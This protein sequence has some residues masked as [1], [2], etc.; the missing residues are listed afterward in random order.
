[1]SCEHVERDL[2]AYLDRELDAASPRWPSAITST[3]ARPAADGSPSARRSS[4]L[5]RAA[6]YYSAPDCLRARVL[7]QTTRARSVRRLLTWAAAAVLVVSVGGGDESVAVGIDARR[8]D[9]G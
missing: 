5:V 1:M 2:D 9:G 7:A 4:R 8:R 6:P 3:G